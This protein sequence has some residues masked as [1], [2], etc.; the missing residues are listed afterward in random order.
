MQRIKLDFSATRRGSPWL[1]WVLLA[2]AAAACL[3][4]GLTYAELRKTLDA[5]EARVAR[6]TPS[7][8][9]VKV[10]AQEV[11]AVRETVQRLSLPWDEL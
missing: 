11:A 3:D 2:V 4:A 7:G 6:R 8:A 9:V 1:G 5:N 10:S